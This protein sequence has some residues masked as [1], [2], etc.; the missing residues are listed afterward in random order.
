[1]APLSL[2]VLSDHPRDSR[3]RALPKLCCWQL[4][5]LLEA[6]ACSLSAGIPT[7]AMAAP[8][9][10]GSPKQ[11]ALDGVD[12]CKSIDEAATNGW[13]RSLS[14]PA[15]TRF[16][17]Q[18]PESLRPNA[19]KLV[20]DYN[21]SLAAIIESLQS[22]RSYR[23]LAE[24]VGDREGFLSIIIR[25]LGAAQDEAQSLFLVLR[26][27]TYDQRLDADAAFLRGIDSLSDDDPDVVES[28]SRAKRWLYWDLAAA[29]ELVTWIRTEADER[30]VN[31]LSAVCHME[32]LDS[33]VESALAA[34]VSS[35]YATR[36]DAGIT[37]IANEI[38]RILRQWIVDIEPSVVEAWRQAQRVRKAEWRRAAGDAVD[39]AALA[40]SSLRL[41][42]SRVKGHIASLAA[43]SGAR[44]QI[45]TQFGQYQA[46]VF[47]CAMG[48]SALGKRLIP[49]ALM[50]ET[51]R[52]WRSVLANKSSVPPATVPAELVQ[53]ISRLA[54][55]QKSIMKQT[56]RA[57]TDEPTVI[58]CLGTADDATVD[59]PQGFASMTERLRSEDRL[60][61]ESIT[62]KYPGFASVSDRSR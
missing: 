29:D 43:I 44:E 62:S 10:A 50:L 45:A 28:L 33:E 57:L 52:A 22:Q 26:S 9:I 42:Q 53:A 59:C 39:T 3:A 36:D 48:E 41:A 25:D 30:P 54:G 1:M 8:P 49:H 32:L 27:S 37:P 14:G 38:E 17:A 6:L 2:S 12:R 4:I 40:K 46:D 61:F 7:H 20:H 24:L 18:V 5:F 47:F 11:G 15:L 21:R 51:A 34:A 23:R 35:I 16:I 56:I 19:S 31:L 58:H 55:I 60:W 13:R